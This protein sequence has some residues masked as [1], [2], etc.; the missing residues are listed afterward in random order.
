M[1]DSNILPQIETQSVNLHFSQKTIQCIIHQ[2]NNQQL[3]T[4]FLKNMVAQQIEHKSDIIDRLDGQNTLDFT[5]I[6]LT[7]S[8]RTDPELRDFYSSFLLDDLI[9]H[10]KQFFTSIFSKQQDQA[11][12]NGSMLLRHYGLIQQGFNEKHFDLI[13]QHFVL[14]LEDSWVIQGCDSRCRLHSKFRPPRV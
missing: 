4:T 9:E 14:E 12:L 10:K 5:I 3:Y 11:K 1:L 6:G 2:A 8:L 7:K 13:V